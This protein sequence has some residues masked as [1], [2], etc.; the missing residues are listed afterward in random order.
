M[1]LFKVFGKAAAGERL[2]RMRRSP[3]YKGDRFENLVPTEVTV[4]GTSFW[5][6]LKE[7]RNRP[8][9]TA[10]AGRLPAV[11]TDLRAL[12]DQGVWVVWFGHSS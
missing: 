11:M 1:A 8:A 9:D 4:K 12:P 6:M 5:K 7:Y 3:N 10:P 2:E